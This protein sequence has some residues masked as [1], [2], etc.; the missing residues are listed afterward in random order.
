MKIGH[1]YRQEFSYQTLYFLARSEQRNGGF[2]GVLVTKDHT[3]PR[4]APKAKKTTV[5]NGPL[6]TATHWSVLW[7]YTEEVP[8][9]VRDAARNKS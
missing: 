5:S 9:S 4:A 7:R 3:R 2:S 6:G 1:W 8:E